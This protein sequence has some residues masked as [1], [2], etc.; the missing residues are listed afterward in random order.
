MA[1]RSARLILGSTDQNHAP[2]SRVPRGAVRFDF[3]LDYS[4][5]GRARDSVILIAVVQSPTNTLTAP[6]LAHPN[7]VEVTRRS[8][9][10][11]AARYRRAPP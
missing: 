2:E 5:D 3:D 11:A 10:I 1:P 4:F 8:A 7:L 9:L 6:D